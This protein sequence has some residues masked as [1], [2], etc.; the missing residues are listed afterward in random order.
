MKVLK[1]EVIASRGEIQ[2]TIAERNVLVELA[3]LNLPFLPKLHYSFQTNDSL[4]LVMDFIN[5]GELFFHLQREGR[6]SEERTRF[7]SAQLVAC[8]AAIHKAG[9]IYRD[10]KPE[11]VLLS[12][13]GNIILTDFGLSKAGL[14]TPDARTSTFCG[15]PEYLAPEIIK[16]DPYTKTV[17]WWS[18]GTLTYEMMAGCPPF[19]SN[20]KD[21]IYYE[22]MRA[23][24]VIPPEFTPEAADLC[25]RFIERDPA[26]RLQDIE[27]IR[28]TSLV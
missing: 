20:D 14:N 25:K 27:E 5:G 4:Y 15:T 16:G 28:K 11:N 21:N 13:T 1:K 2:H 23:P 19:Y 10:L 7:Y 3:K 6:F 26:K 12:S 9:I 17:D 22:I 24:L 8:I 18:V